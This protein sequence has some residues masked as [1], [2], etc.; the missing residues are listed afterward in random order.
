M[1]I[2]FHVV[3]ALGLIIGEDGKVERVPRLDFTRFRFRNQWEKKI[4]NFTK[5]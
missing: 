4:E 1:N 5:G 3:C 2:L